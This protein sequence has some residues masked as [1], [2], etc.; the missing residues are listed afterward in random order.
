MPWRKERQ[1]SPKYWCTSVRKQYIAT[2]RAAI[3]VFTN[4]KTSQFAYRP[5]CLVLA[6]SCLKL[7]FIRCILFQFF[8][9]NTFKCL[10]VHYIRRRVTSCSECGAQFD[11]RPVH[12][13]LMAYKVKVARVIAIYLLQI[14]HIHPYAPDLRIIFE[15]VT[16]S[17]NKQR[18]SNYLYF[19]W[20]YLSTK[21]TVGSKKWLI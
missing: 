12:V 6:L 20:F 11:P 10:T 19:L 14:R 15:I 2:K 1:V 13:G 4:L 21:G 18:G 7:H 5:Y 16:L 8:P 17:L 9:I 3:R